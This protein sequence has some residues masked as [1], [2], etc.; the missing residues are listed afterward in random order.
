MG[1][2][3]E[4]P[5]NDRLS[6]AAAGRF[7]FPGTSISVNRMGY[8]A[9]QLAGPHVFGEPGDP[10]EARAVLRERWRSASTI[11]TPAITTAPMSP[12]AS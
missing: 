11:L 9:M 1:L 3:K 12:I 5:M 10:A 7:T 2:E 8:G 4:T 6:A